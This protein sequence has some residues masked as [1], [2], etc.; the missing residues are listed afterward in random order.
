MRSDVSPRS[1]VVGGAGGA[2]VAA[3]GI[4]ARLITRFNGA[5]AA[6][7]RTAELTFVSQLVRPDR[8]AAFGAHQGLL[9]DALRDYGVRVRYVL[10]GDRPPESAHLD[11]NDLASRC[12]S[13]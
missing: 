9:E 11:E 5:G 8:Q 13:C 3:G 4:R 12:G 6:A 1:G 2:D 10:H 7:R